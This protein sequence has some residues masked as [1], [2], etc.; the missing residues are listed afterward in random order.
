MRVKLCNRLGWAYLTLGT[1]GCCASAMEAKGPAQMLE[2]QGPKWRTRLRALW[3]MAAQCGDRW[4]VFAVYQ[5]V[6]NRQSTDC[7]DCFAYAF[8]EFAPNQ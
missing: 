6:S 4:R 5:V 3:R 2:R 1:S 7:C 8:D